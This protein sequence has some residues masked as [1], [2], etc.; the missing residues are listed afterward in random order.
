MRRQALRQD[1]RP[2]A[3]VI[4]ARQTQG[5]PSDPYRHLISGLAELIGL[6]GLY[7]TMA[8]GCALLVNGVSIT[9]HGG[10]SVAGGECDRVDIFADFGAFPE[11]RGVEIMRRL[12]EVNLL[13]SS[14]GTP[15]L[16][17]DAD[18]GRVVLAWHHVL[19][20]AT[21][22]RLLESLQL[23][24]QQA[25]EWRASYYLDERAHHGD[26]RHAVPV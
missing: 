23:A 19:R 18:T 13:L 12:L 17:L 26:L 21:P 3:V 15:R 7:D 25:L 10:A 24:A 16:G 20:D 2:L 6:T 14:A 1:L 11:D 5:M 8:E 9:M 22:T 4:S